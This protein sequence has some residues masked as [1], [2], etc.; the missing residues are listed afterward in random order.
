[1]AMGGG[2]STKE[3]VPYI[4]MTPMIDILLVLLIIFMV[5]S[6]RSLIASNR[7]FLKDRRRI[8]QNNR[9]IRWPCWLRSRWTASRSS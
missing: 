8:C 2:A 5:I 7:E 3:A 1:M 6:P 9:R 4:N